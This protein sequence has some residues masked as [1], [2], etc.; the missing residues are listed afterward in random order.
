MGRVHVIGSAYTYI[1]DRMAIPAKII[2]VFVKVLDFKKE[3]GIREKA[4][5]ASHHIETVGSAY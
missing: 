5:D 3:L 2:H 4:V 1:I